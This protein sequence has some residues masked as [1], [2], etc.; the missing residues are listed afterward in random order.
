MRATSPQLCL[1]SAEIMPTEVSQ[2]EI[3]MQG[4]PQSLRSQHQNRVR[5]AKADLAKYKKLSREIQTQL[6]RTDLLSSNRR[7]GLPS[8]DEP[9]GTTSDRQRLLSGTALLEDGSKRLQESQ[10][11]A[12]ETEEQGAD[13]LINLRRQREQIENSRNAVRNIL[14]VNIDDMLIIVTA[15]HRRFLYRPCLR[16]VE[17]DDQT[18]CLV[19]IVVSD[20]QNF[21]HRWI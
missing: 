14:I 11:V 3:E 6:A 1:A 21:S 2:M 12:L 9:F 18:V 16:N 17:K 20:S 5:A 13:I 4:T 10:R 8:S 7:A 15:L 19:S